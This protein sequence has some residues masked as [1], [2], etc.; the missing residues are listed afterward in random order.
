[1][2]LQR[3]STPVRAARSRPSRAG[4]SAARSQPLISKRGRR[5]RRGGGR[6]DGAPLGG[7]RRR[8]RDRRSCCCGPAPTSN[9]A[10][11]YGVTPLSLAATNGNAA[12]MATLLKA[13]ADP[14][15][16]LRRGRDGAD[17]GGAHRQIPTP[18]KLLLSHGANVN[19]RG[20]WHGETALMWA[21]A[22]NHAGRRDAARRATAR[23]STPA[24]ISWSSRRF[25]C[26]AADAWC[27]TPLP[28]RA[29]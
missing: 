29:A 16:P 26:D 21:A 28:R 23:T 11:R 4:R 6:H 24:R 5:E 7:A 14:N 1:M 22:E 13:G 19:A 2:R 3:R 27:P 12:I 25:R 18:C 20:R 8:P 10:N 17:D 9:A 15:T